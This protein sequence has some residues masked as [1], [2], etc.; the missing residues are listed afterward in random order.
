M[1]ASLNSAIHT[2]QEAARNEAVELY[3]IFLR[4]K[5]LVNKFEKYIGSV[6]N[7]LHDYAISLFQN[8]NNEKIID[9][10]SRLIGL[11]HYLDWI[12]IAD[13]KIQREYPT[14][15][16]FGEDDEDF[17]DYRNY[18]N[19]NIQNP[20]HEKYGGYNDYDDRTIDDAFEGDPTSTWNVD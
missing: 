6:D 3:L 9:D 19:F 1:R 12:S 11:N 13:R 4:N 5:I 15:F 17:E 20:D 16:D 8:R 2:I 7:D 18:R 14:M 10:D